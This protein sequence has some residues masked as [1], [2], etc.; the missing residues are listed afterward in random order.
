MATLYQYFL[1]E[2]NMKGV[3]LSECSGNT[4]QWQLSEYLPGAHVSSTLLMEPPAPSLVQ[5]LACHACLGDVTG[6][7]DR[8]L[9]NYIVSD[10]VLYALDISYLFWPNNADYVDLYIAGGQSEATVLAHYPDC[11]TLYW[12]AYQAC[13]EVLQEKQAALIQRIDAVLTRTTDCSQATQYLTHHL[14]MPQYVAQRKQAVERQL[15]TY[16]QRLKRKQTLADY[17]EKQG[18]Y[19][20]LTPREKMHYWANKDRLTAF[21]LDKT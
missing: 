17:V 20:T 9:E 7:G 18:R 21:F 1:Q 11:A 6:R 8:H 3:S 16:A 19:T 12:Q 15:V 5:Q 10:G 13:Y 14:A 2:I 4:T